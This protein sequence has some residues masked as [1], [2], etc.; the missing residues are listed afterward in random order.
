MYSGKLKME[1]GEV[2]TKKYK[3]VGSVWKELETDAKISFENVFVLK[4]KRQS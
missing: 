1:G 3:K 4:R 2:E